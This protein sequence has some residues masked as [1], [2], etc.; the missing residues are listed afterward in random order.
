MENQPHQDGK[1]EPEDSLK[2]VSKL[3]RKKS[4]DIQQ[5]HYVA[6]SRAIKKWFKEFPDDS[7]SDIQYVSPTYINF[8]NQA[9][10]ELEKEDKDK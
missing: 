10:D 9:L 7:Y 5:R 6:K 1:D 4:F 3:D 8:Y 2:E